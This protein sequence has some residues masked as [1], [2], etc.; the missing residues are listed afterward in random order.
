MIGVTGQVLSD[1]TRKSRMVKGQSCSP[2]S[3]LDKGMLSCWGRL[4]ICIS[5][6]DLLNSMDVD[7]F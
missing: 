7:V 3:L 6:T 1:N 5:V 2:N 4:F